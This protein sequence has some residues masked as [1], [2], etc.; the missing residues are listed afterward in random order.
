MILAAKELKN[1]GFVISLKESWKQ[2]EYVKKANL[3]NVYLKNFVP[4]KELL[5]D[6]R[7]FAF[8]SHG[9]GNSIIESLYYGKPLIGF[10]ISA[11]QQGTCYRV[12]LLGVGISL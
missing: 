12:E 4:Q 2:Y 10:P 3:S 11:D 8:I 1:V 6:K 5:N 7:I 9:G